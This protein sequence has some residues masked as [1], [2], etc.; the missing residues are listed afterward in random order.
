[1]SI[2]PI[3]IEE[4]DDNISILSYDDLI[5][6]NEEPINPSSVIE[7]DDTNYE[8]ASDDTGYDENMDHKVIHM[9]RQSVIRKTLTKFRK[10]IDEQKS[11]TLIGSTLIPTSSKHSY[12]KYFKRKIYIPIVLLVM[13]ITGVI[14][15][16]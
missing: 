11:G 13:G 15:V 4:E 12:F 9:R 14:I 6:T 8:T 5:Y 10:S 2:I 3:N 1:M 7:N 16:L